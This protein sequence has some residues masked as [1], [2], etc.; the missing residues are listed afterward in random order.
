MSCIGGKVDENRIVVIGPGR[1]TN[2][3]GVFNAYGIFASRDYSDLTS[4]PR[5]ADITIANN[6]VRENPM[7]EG[8]DTHAGE[9]IA[10]TG[11]RILNCRFGPISVGSSMN[12]AGVDAFGPKNVNVIGNVIS[13]DKSDQEWPVGSP[14]VYGIIF[15]GADADPGTGCIVGNLVENYGDQSN[16]STSGAIYMYKTVGLVVDGNMI[17]N[18]APVGIQID[19]RNRGFAVT[20]NT[21]VDP[22]SNTASVPVAAIHPAYGDNTGAISNNVI[23]RRGKIAT[24][25]IDQPSAFAVRIEGY[26]GDSI[27]LGPNYSEAGSYLRDPLG[28]VTDGNLMLTPKPSATPQWNGEMLFEKTSNSTIT[29]KLKGSDGVVRSKALDLA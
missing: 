2:A 22:W 6:E 5:S 1:D 19:N 13:N 28:I 18:P 3:S 25:T 17:V 4:C 16:S 23:T 24:Y 10:I 15:Q 20:N 12:S 26:P 7:W 9:R 21:I 14:P 8:I 29:L 11:N 27:V